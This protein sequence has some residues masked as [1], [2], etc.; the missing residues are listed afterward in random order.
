[1]MPAQ[2]E[3]SGRTRDC[4]KTVILFNNISALL[5]DDKE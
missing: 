2:C 5:R 3:K 4:G 1:M